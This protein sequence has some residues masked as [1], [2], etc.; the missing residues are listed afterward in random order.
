MT[1]AESGLPPSPLVEKAFGVT[2]SDDVALL[3]AQVLSQASRSNDPEVLAAHMMAF[4]SQKE[5]THDKLEAEFS[6]R[7][8]DIVEGIR[9]VY[10]KLD[11]K[12]ALSPDD[13][14]KQSFLAVGII[15]LEFAMEKYGRASLDD[16]LI[17]MPKSQT[18][19]KV[20]IVQ[21]SVGGL[22]QRAYD[23]YANGTAA[24]LK[25]TSE[26]ALEARFERALN[27][28][29]TKLAAPKPDAQP[30]PSFGFKIG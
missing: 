5:W 12:P 23:N 29:Q 19:G 25:T 20:T 21:D 1:F 8:A 6:P 10:K 13:G 27:A 4:A 11:G 15:D 18:P 2:G 26:P 7:V 30:K 16:M 22:L 3:S 14:V 17:S 28:L 24:V 9:D